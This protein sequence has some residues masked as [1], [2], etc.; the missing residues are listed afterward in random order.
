MKFSLSIELGNEA[1]QSGFDVAGALEALTFYL[2]D[3]SEHSDTLEPQDGAFIHDT[4][5]NRVGWWAISQ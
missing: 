4:N 2:R 1:M 3:L 5:G